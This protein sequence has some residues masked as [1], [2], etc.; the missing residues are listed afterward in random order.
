MTFI[1]TPFEQRRGR[2]KAN[3]RI[4]TNHLNFV[5]SVCVFFFTTP[6]SLHT[7]RPTSSAMMPFTTQS[8]GE[9]RQERYFQTCTSSARTRRNNPSLRTRI[10]SDMK[11]TAPLAEMHAP[12]KKKVPVLSPADCLL[13]R[14]AIREAWKKSNWMHTCMP[15]QTHPATQILQV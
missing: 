2:Y 6:L 3:L 9:T 14:K 4:A 11:M 5:L 13:R 15:C 7:N 8:V 10:L 12:P 1:A